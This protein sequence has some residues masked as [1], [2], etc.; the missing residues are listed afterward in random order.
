MA[1]NIQ[2][3]YS[4]IVFTTISFFHN[5]T[6]LA[7]RFIIQEVITPRQLQYEYGIVDHIWNTSTAM[8]F[9]AY[10]IAFIAQDRQVRIWAK[11]ASNNIAPTELLQQARATPLPGP[12]SIRSVIGRELMVDDE[13]NTYFDQLQAAWR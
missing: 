2:M 12:L 10:P 11:K 3:H 9:C 4:L 7:C 5:C 6:I 13:S 1:E 8:Y